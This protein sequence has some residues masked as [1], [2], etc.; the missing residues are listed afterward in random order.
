MGKGGRSGWIDSSENVRPKYPRYLYPSDPIEEYGAFSLR[1]TGEESSKDYTLRQF[2]LTR[3]GE[4][5]ETEQRN[6]FHFHFLGWPGAA[7]P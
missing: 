5:G 7:T 6:I 1:N 2:T 3:L 4:A